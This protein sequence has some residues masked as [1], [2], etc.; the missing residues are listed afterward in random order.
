MLSTGEVINGYR[1]ERLLGQGG[2]GVV[3]EAVQLSL[4][5]HVAIKV[6]T[7]GLSGDE[8]FRNRFRREAHL[9]AGFSHP[10]IVTVHDFGETDGALSIS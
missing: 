1:I 2:M 9:Q 7:A 4:Q 10:R 5:R 6:L 8:E 3:Y